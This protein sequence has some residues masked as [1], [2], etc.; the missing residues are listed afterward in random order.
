MKVYKNRLKS[1]FKSLVKFEIFK[2][3]DSEAKLGMLMVMKNIYSQEGIRK[4]FSGVEAR[5]FWITIGGFI[6]LGTL[7]KIKN[8]LQ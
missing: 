1:L 7:E 6:Y 3:T 4:L 2:T 5:V 8:F